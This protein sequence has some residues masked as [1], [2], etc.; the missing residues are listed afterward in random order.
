M[1]AADTNTGDADR[2]GGARAFVE[3]AEWT[4]A[5]R[6]DHQWLSRRWC[7][8]HGL[9]AEFVAFAALIRDK[10][11]AR[12]MDGTAWQAMDIDGL[13]FWCCGYPLQVESTHV[14][15]RSLPEQQLTFDIGPPGAVHQGS[16][17]STPR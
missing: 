8:E 5:R 4:T 3:L 9:E 14:I 10:G 2:L 15:N 7:L 17:A 11:Y 12:P 16:R 1:P 13:T 6:G